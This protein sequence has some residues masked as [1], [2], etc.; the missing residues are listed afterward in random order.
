MATATLN[1]NITQPSVSQELRIAATAASMSDLGSTRQVRLNES[2]LPS[3]IPSGAIL[4]VKA[5][6]FSELK[7]G[8]LIC[9]RVGSTLVVRRFVKTKMTRSNTFLLTAKEGFDKKE[10]I[11]RTSLIGKVEKVCCGGTSYDP[12]QREGILTQFWGKLTE[13]GTHKPFGIFKAA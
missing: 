8:D 2:E 5:V 7:M 6:K 4:N 12:A 9:V 11:A 10:A 3:L 13:Y 1:R